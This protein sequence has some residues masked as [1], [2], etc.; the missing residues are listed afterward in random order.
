M[1]HDVLF[2][3]MCLHGL[4][5]KHSEGAKSQDPRKMKIAKSWIYKINSEH[6]PNR[7][8][9]TDHLAEPPTLRCTT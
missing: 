1:L 7:T 5:Q 8:Q 4:C 9:Q 2:L 3:S 6:E